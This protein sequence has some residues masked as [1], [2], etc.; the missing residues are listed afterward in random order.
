MKADVIKSHQTTAVGQ[1]FTPELQ[2]AAIT[3]AKPTFAL[4]NVVLNPS[5]GQ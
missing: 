4:S 3:Q 1:R 5:R 2:D